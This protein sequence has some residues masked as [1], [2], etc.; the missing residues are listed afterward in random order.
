MEL[1]MVMVGM[2]IVGIISINIFVL[3][4]EIYNDVINHKETVNANRLAVSRTARELNLQRDKNHL[5]I[6]SASV[7]QFVT[8]IIDTLEYDL[9]DDQVSIT[10]NN[11]SKRGIADNVISNISN[12][13][14]HDSTGSE[15]LPLPLSTSLRDNVWFIKLKIQTGFL[16]DTLTLETK[17]F[18]QN[19]NYGF[20]MPYHD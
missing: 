6:A 7:I 3:G 10:K 1:V 18:P 5:E 11:G 2:G 15:L 8:P 13:S 12:F 16:G 19:L 9:S 20:R 4:V 17:V 14:Y